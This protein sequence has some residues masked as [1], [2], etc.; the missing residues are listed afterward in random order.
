MPI[1]ILLAEHDPSFQ[2]K[3]REM[4]DILD[5]CEILGNARDGQEAIQMATLFHPDIAFISHD[6]PGMSGAQTCEILNMLEPDIMTVLIAH[7]ESPADLESAMCAGVRGLITKDIDA[8]KLAKL[9]TKLVEVRI[10]RHSPEYLEW[11]DPSKHPKIISVSGAKGGVGKTTISVNLAVALAQRHPNKVA[12]LDLHTQFGDV[13]TMLNLR[14]ERAIMDM[15]SISTDL[16]AESLQGYIMKHSSGLH[17]LVTSINPYPPDALSTESLDNLFYLL[18]RSYRYIVI[19]VPAIMQK[20]TL[21]AMA[22]SSH[23]LLIANLFDLTTATDTMKLCVAL[24]EENI[25]KEHIG[26]II[27]RVS[28]VNQLQSSDIARVF[29]NHIVASIPNDKR[30]V[31]AVNDGNPL[32]ANCGDCPWKESMEELADFVTGTK[33]SKNDSDNSPARRWL[34]NLGVMSHGTTR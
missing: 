20:I 16:D 5:E 27:N 34:F 31:A 11:K 23:I 4:V 3:T 28:K 1:R 10:R 15:E 26:I 19:D 21:H 12:L 14:P 33:H 30:L 32:A 17:V 8:A 18:K 2:S 7:T 24:Q 6:L 9:I 22:Y 13:A 29:D 25:P